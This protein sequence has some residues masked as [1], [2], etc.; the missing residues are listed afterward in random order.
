MYHLTDLPS[1]V[2]GD[3][4]VMFDPHAKYLPGINPAQ[5][6]LKIA[7][8]K[9]NLL[10][11]FPDAFKPYLHFGCTLREGYKGTLFRFPLRSPDVVSDITSASYPVH[12]V[13]SL[14]ETFRTQASK[15]LLFV[16]NVQ[17]ISVHVKREV[18]R[19]SW[20]DTDEAAKSTG[21]DCHGLPAGQH[22]APVRGKHQPHAVQIQPA[23][24][25]C[26]DCERQFAWI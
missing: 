20:H 15:A 11:Q 8:Q 10:S 13:E 17:N 21:H 24:V 1:F 23:V 25:P 14:L 22:G 9:A 18:Q 26:R 6:G 4:L 5:P 16:K 19:L 7:F 12:K 3:Y 2:S